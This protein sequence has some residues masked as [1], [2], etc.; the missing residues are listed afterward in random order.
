MSSL[1][2]A[3][4]LLHSVST[5][6]LAKTL[7]DLPP[8]I[9]MPASKQCCHQLLAV[10]DTIL[11]ILASAFSEWSATKSFKEKLAWL[12][13]LPYGRGPADTLLSCGCVEP[14]LDRDSDEESR[15]P[16]GFPTTGTPTT[17]RLRF[18]KPLDP[19]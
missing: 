9:M 14:V 15:E 2:L 17:H 5:S 12:P 3:A 6:L 16:A 13:R 18:E 11:P 7:F 1:K 8:F 4:R 10:L 19:R